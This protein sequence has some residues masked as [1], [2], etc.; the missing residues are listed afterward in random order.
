[1]RSHKEILGGLYGLLIGDAIGVPFE[2]RPSEDLVNFGKDKIDYPFTDEMSKGFDRSHKS[3][4]FAAWSDDGAL[5]LA[6]LDSLLEQ[7]VFDL[8]RAAAKML[9]WYKNQRYAVDNVLFD[10][11]NQTRVSMRAMMAGE[12]P[13]SSGLSAENQNGNG[14][15]M[16]VLPLSFINYKTP[17]SMIF[18]AMDS[19]LPTHAHV[20]SQVCCA[21]YVAMAIAVIEKHE[22]PLEHA[23]E[24]LR[25]V[26]TDKS[27]HTE[28]TELDGILAARSTFTRGSPYVVDTLWSALECFEQATDFADCAKRA[29]LMGNDTD[30]TSCVACGLYGLKHG[31]DAIPV[32]WR[33]VLPREK[34]FV[35]ILET[36]DATPERSPRITP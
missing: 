16:R 7:D 4:P 34:D 12:P 32:A 5:A 14:A 3:A 9:S 8:D 28:N 31:F 18:A 25:G 13:D 24:V 1:M 19:S 29:I 30:T 10:I 15:L 17:E 33:D 6:L 11:G 27:L 23:T 20:R 2:F 36:L 35:R 26:F 22:N 21:L